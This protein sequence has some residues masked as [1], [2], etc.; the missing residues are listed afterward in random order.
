[1][2]DLPQRTPAVVLDDVTLTYG[3]GAMAVTAIKNVSLEVRRG[4]GTF[5]DGPFGQRQD[6]CS[7]AHRRSA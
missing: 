3:A 1:M 6:E 2:R 5:A 4:E 7:A